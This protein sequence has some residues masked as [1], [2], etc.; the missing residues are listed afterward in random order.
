MAIIGFVP[1]LVVYALGRIVDALIKHNWIDFM[2]FATI[3]KLSPIIVTYYLFYFNTVVPGN[4]IRT[5]LRSVAIHCLLERK[6]RLEIEEQK[7]KEQKTNVFHLEKKGKKNSLT[8]SANNSSPLSSLIPKKKAKAKA[9]KSS[10]ILKEEGS[11]SSSSQNDTMK[12]PTLLTEE[13]SKKDSFEGSH[14]KNIA[15]ETSTTEVSTHAPQKSTSNLLAS[16]ASKNPDNK[17]E[18]E[19]E[20]KIDVKP[21]FEVGIMSAGAIKAFD[22]KMSIN[23]NKM[24]SLKAEDLA[25]N[26]L[27]A[28]II[29]LFA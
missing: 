14:D 16:E 24:P 7:R 18:L 20:D 6:K 29:V 26:N 19:N 12:A 17:V 2:I 9:K 8:N 11:S 25:S 23:Y 10:S 22:S 4:H 3:S 1:S 5:D 15:T 21:S 13:V 28:V 27:I